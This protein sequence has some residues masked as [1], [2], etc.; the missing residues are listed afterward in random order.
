MCVFCDI[1]KGTIPCYKVYEDD[2]VLAFLDIS[3]ATKGHTLVIPK[4]HYDSLLECPEE[5]AGSLMKVVTSL[6]KTLVK[7]LDAKGINVL[8]NANEVAGQT[9]SHLH[10]HLIP[11]YSDE[12]GFQTQFKVNEHPN[13]EEILSLLQ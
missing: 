4:S 8:T 6:S 9:V 12:D 10:F 2:Q 13:Y 3:Q 5:E 11:R 1:V 7:K